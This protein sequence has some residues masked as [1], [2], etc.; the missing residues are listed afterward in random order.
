[1]Y[2]LRRAGPLAGM[3]GAAYCYNDDMLPLKKTIHAFVGNESHPQ[4]YDS[5]GEMFPRQKWNYNWDLR[6]P[7]SLIENKEFDSASEEKRKEMI[8]ER[9]STATRNII[10]IRHGQ[11]KIESQ[12]DKGLTELGREQAALVGERLARS[13]LKIT[14]LTMSTMDRATETA[15]IILSKGAPYPPEPPVSHW[16]P[17]KL[18]FFQ[19]GSRIEAAFR[20]Y[21]HR[22]SPK[23]TEDSYEVVVCHANVIRYFVCRALQFPPEGWLRMSLGNGSI[24]WLIIRPNGRVSIRNL[25]D[26]GHLP[27]EKISYS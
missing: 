2:L 22:A 11:Y 17:N 4:A 13:G 23:Q 25:G 9:T 1:M 16:K 19:E 12:E 10:L 21:F 26:I 20:N 18:E 3:V 27:P 6:D 14:N 5:F 8:A 15:N 24:T 7:K